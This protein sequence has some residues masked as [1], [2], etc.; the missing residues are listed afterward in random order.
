MNSDN[1][2]DTT[3]L[4]NVTSCHH[5]FAKKVLQAIACGEEQNLYKRDM[6]CNAI[7]ATHWP[8]AIQS[9][10]LHESN[11]RAVPG[12][13]Q[14][15]VRYGFRL[16]K[17]VLLRSRKDIATSF[18]EQF[19]DCP[20]TISTIMREFPQ[21]ACT[22]TTR[23]LERNT[24]PVHANARRL[25]NAINKAVKPTL[26][27]K[28]LPTSCRDLVCLTM[29]QAANVVPS[30][31]L[32][33]NENCANGTCKN[34][35]NKLPI[36]LTAPLKNVEVKYA[37]WRSEEKTFT[38]E[39][40]GKRV[41]ITKSVYSL[42]PDSCKL[43]VALERLEDMCK[44]LRKHIYTSHKQWD[45]H[46]QQRLNL[47]RN[48]FISIE[49]FQ[50]NL[51]VRNDEAPTSCAY[52]ANKLTV[53]M[54]PICIEYRADDGSIAK[55]AITF[56]SEDKDHSNQQVQQFEKRMFEIV[57][58]KLKRPMTKW[59]RYSDGCGGQF[60]SGF[61]VADLLEAP[62][63][64]QVTDTTFNFFESHEGKSCSD[65]I[66][67]IVKCAFMRGILKKRAPVQSVDGILSIILEEAKPSTEK[68]TSFIVEKFGWFKK[69][70]PTSRNYCKVKG[71]MGLHSLKL[72]DGKI[73]LRDLTC[74]A[75]PVDG[76]CNDCKSLSQVDKS[77]VKVPEEI[78]YFEVE[79][80]NDD[81]DD[82]E[83][84]DGECRDDDDNGFTDDTSDES[85][86]EEDV[87]FTPGDVIW[88]KHGRIW[89]PA[90]ICCLNDK[91]PHLQNS[92][93][94]QKDTLIVKW[95]GEDNY[96]AVNANQ[97]DILG[98][99]LVDASRAAR[100][101]YIMQEYNIALGQKLA[102]E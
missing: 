58:E 73:T 28:T 88:A 41:S 47:D 91:P 16:P 86:E 55:M 39:M 32:S 30:K 56:L 62:E 10:V 83:P 57:R 87:E 1:Q 68:F 100:S 89:Y 24:C 90:K 54:Y 38:K 42:C 96:S 60:K 49:D 46:N 63:T 48:T 78:E 43:S 98:E 12:K 8:E 7:K 3:I 72:H 95:Y 77:K 69:K 93:L 20:F 40:K 70:L 76:L 26:K 17:Y 85:E 92:F 19:P 21:N 36:N 84:E 82:S 4:A 23:D 9:F 15:S 18:K 34:C 2:S 52:S 81:D 45:A 102:F 51:D 50:M 65:S 74:T 13:E 71:I 99:N 61:C 67:S 35:S 5:S 44:P 101:K 33:W 79:E 11:S 53:A 94:V 31:P 64:F 6:K 66:G 80:V 25:N 29:C 14:V 59:I 37:Q 97:V 75:C 22:P 27:D